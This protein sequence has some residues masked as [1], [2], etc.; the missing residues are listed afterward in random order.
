MKKFIKFMYYIYIILI[1]IFPLRINFNVYL[2]S[3]VS[4]LISLVILIILALK[5]DNR[6]YNLN[7]LEK[8]LSIT[9]KI[10][11]INQ[12]FQAIRMKG[13]ILFHCE[14]IGPVLL[15]VVSIYYFKFNRD[16]L[17]D[18]LRFLKVTII[19]AIGSWIIFYF[20]NISRI[21]L[22]GLN[23]TITKFS[24][25]NAL[26]GEDRFEWL[27]RHKSEFA[28]LCTFLTIYILNLYKSLVCKFILV[29]LCIIGIYLSK[30]STALIIYTITIFAILLIKFTC[31]IKNKKLR[32]VIVDIYVSIIGITAYFNL[33]III[34]AINSALAGRDLETLG[35][36]TFIWGS[37]ITTLKNNIL[38]YGSSV[39]IN[40]I[41]NPMYNFTAYSNAHNSYLQDFLE[42]GV[43]GG[44]IFLAINIIIF[45]ILFKEN[46]ESALIFLSIFAINQMD[47]GMYRINVHI[48]YL[49]I[50]M[51]LALNQFKNDKL[52][53]KNN[54]ECDN[55]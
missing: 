11:I 42:S 5:K 25:S 20:L 55:S 15:C 40:F 52:I 35:S 8:I 50:T 24:E 45:I 27:T 3:I 33:Y 31:L 29:F 51:I 48:M 32:I 39:G 23:V 47:I 22:I 1:L 21:D 12:I 19:I 53:L 44:I 43:F 18:I 4:I 54:I 49:M 10:Y 13:D 37:A 17:Y 30:S 7:R 38:G 26:W 34:D 41:A 2:G 46:Y 14:K 28:V 16:I 36:R 9:C 6:K